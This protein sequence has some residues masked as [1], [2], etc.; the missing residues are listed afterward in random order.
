MMNDVDAYADSKDY[1]TEKKLG[2]ILETLFPDSTF[3]HNKTVPGSGLRTRPDYRCPDEMLIVEFDGPTHFTS[4]SVCLRD[5]LKDS[6]YKS[7][8]YEIVRIPYFIQ[9]DRYTASLFFKSDYCNDVRVR[10]FPHGFI[11]KNAVTPAFFCPLGIERFNHLWKKYFHN[12]NQESFGEFYTERMFW[13]QIVAYRRNP[14]EVF[15][16]DFVESNRALLEA[17]VEFGYPT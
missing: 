3:I 9:V 10:E 12:S 5:E 7:M 16:P 11:T 14:L 13:L 8:G 15:P 1:L 6:T 2:V 4:P 17:V